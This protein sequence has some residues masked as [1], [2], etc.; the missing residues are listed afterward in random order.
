MSTSP[1]LLT[2][3]I[4]VNAVMSNFFA[5]CVIMSQNSREI[6]IETR[7]G[8]KSNAN[9]LAEDHHIRTVDHKLT[10]TRTTTETGSHKDRITT[11][12]RTIRGRHMN[13]AKNDHTMVQ[14]NL[15]V[16]AIITAK[17]MITQVAL[18]AECTITIREHV[19]S[20]AVFDVMLVMD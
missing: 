2:D 4:L 3:F 15:M 16:Y 10:R 8:H 11:D 5:P 1:N 7:Y 13:A 6:K 19:G 14:N 12:T 20:I 18:T 17:H 9:L